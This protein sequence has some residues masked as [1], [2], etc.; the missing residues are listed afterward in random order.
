MSLKELFFALL[1]FKSITPND[2]GAFEFIKNYMKDWEVVHVDVEDTKNLILYKKFSKGPHISFAG[3]IDVVPP[4]DGWRSDA[5]IPKEENGYIYARGTQDMK[6]GICAF[7]AA[8]KSIKYFNGTLSLLLTSDEEGD[9]FYGTIEILKY[10]KKENFLP[11]AVV[12][13]EPT[14]DNFFGD[15]IKVGRR[16]SINGVVE[17]FGLQGHAAYPEKANNTIHL[18]API[19][20]KLAG[21]FFD[22][23]D[24]FFAPSQ[25]V[26]TDVRSGLE[27]S[28]VTPGYLK[29][30]F[31]VRNSTKTSKEDIENYLK[32]VLNG[33]DFKIELS[34][35]SYPFITS[36]ESLLVKKMTNAV[37]KVTKNTPKHSTAGGTS[38]ARFMGEFGIDVVEFGVKNDTIHAPNERVLFEE[39]ES[40][41][42]VFETFI[43]EYNQT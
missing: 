26:L 35:G 20:D 6:S 42:E 43:K 41:K 25:L 13:A 3:H 10:L 22:N 16:G 17:L 8:C 18:V 37:K 29:L 14:C 21:H 27:V 34:Q 5:F 7:L 15:S 38:D 28:N 36:K 9:A 30:M 2:D 4:G 24:E 23:G 19:L 32:S 11:D 39:V 33:L 31:N 40:L 1:K 12:V